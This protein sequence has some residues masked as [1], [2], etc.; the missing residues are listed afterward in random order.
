MYRIS[1][2][3]Q[4]QAW[5]LIGAF[6]LW[7]LF[8]P[9]PPTHAQ[10]LSGNLVAYAGGAGRERFNTVVELSNGTILVGGA[11]D[12]LDWIAPPVPRIELDAAGIHNALG[13][14][15][16]G[17]VLHL[18]RDFSTVLRVVHF[19]RG[20]V[21]DVRFV[22]TTSRP[23][24]PT[25]DLFLSGTTRDTRTNNGG[26]F[27]ARL[28]NNFV[29]GVPDALAWVRNVWAEGDHQA[30]Q[31]WDV[32][33]DGKVVYTTGKPFSPDWVGVYRLQA[34]GSNDVVEDWR[35]HEGVDVA[36][37][38]AVSGEWTPAS[39]RPDVRVLQSG[40]AFK[41]AGRITL[42]SWTSDDYDAVIGDGNGGTKR[43]RWPMDL[44][45]S[46][47]GNPL[48]PAAS[49]GGPGY[50]GYRIGSNPTQR[51]GGVAIDRRTNDLYVGFSIQSR[52]PDGNPDF[53][54][55]VLALTASGALKWWSRLYSET[56]ANSTPDQYVDGLAIDYAQNNLVVLARCHGNNTYNLWRGNSIAPTQ[57]PLNPGTAFHNQFTGTN[58]NIHISW[59][60]KL[61]TT[62]GTLMYASYVADYEDQMAGT[63]TLYSEPIH[64]GWPSHN[65]G[66]PQLN[67]TRCQT[68]VRVDNTGRVYL[69][70]KGRRVITTSNAHQKMLKKTQGVSAWSAWVRVFEPDLK[71]LAYSSLLSG[72][73]NALT[74]AGGDNTE[75]RGV[76]PTSGGVLVVGHQKADAAGAAAGNPVPTRNEPAWA[77]PRPSG[78]SALFGR[79]PFFG[80]ARPPRLPGTT[81]F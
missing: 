30:N 71:T 10:S 39:S 49:P 52:L 20:A 38:M 61:R 13:T 41:T 45:F 17:F 40:I 73:W 81:P 59:L 24:Q 60:G 69:L 54:P 58:G 55:A 5:L 68:D 34:D 7:T 3:P 47:P 32:G 27:I 29:A 44:F 9:A 8:L 12:D 14:N 22:R 1:R 33:S 72:T 74:G 31:P 57:N 77:S 23:G 67:T 35:Y 62:D 4:H 50:T 76:F 11:A 70:G 48:N 2:L 78:E 19:P 64:D 18:S 42:R 43:G 75:L 16:I 80:P 79:L 21:E 26:Y 53:E 56:P 66:W 28:N 51:I 36:T 25:G 46:G 37:G 6:A 65:A 15:R 63:G